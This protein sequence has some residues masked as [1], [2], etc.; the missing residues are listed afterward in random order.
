MNKSIIFMLL[1]VAGIAPKIRATGLLDSLRM[2]QIAGKNVV[3]HRADK[4]QS[5]YALL[6]KY[7]SS[8]ADFKE[9]NPGAD[10]NLQLGKVYKLA[11]GKPIKTAKVA[12]TPNKKA[13]KADYLKVEPGMTLYAVSR[14]TGLSVATIKKLNNL[15]DDNIE[16]GQMLLVNEQMSLGSIASHEVKHEDVKPETHVE[17]VVVTVKP[18][19]KPAVTQKVEKATEPKPEISAKT[20]VVEVKPKAEA[21]KKEEVKVITEPKKPVVEAPKE[22]VAAQKEEKNKELNQPLPTVEN[23]EAL[24]ISKTEEGV[25]EAIELESKSGKYLALHKSA[26]IGTL[27]QV[28]NETTGA[29]V[30]VKI[31]G[32]LPKLEQNENVVVKLSPKAMSRVSP[33][34]KRFR[35]KVFY[36][37]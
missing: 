25:A 2:E 19:E 21:P 16:V 22:V 18:E 23:T 37:L 31:V 26:P 20:E 12:A 8:M 35:A 3:L 4:G 13:A 15:K 10:I 33:V 17:R 32:K 28:R 27:M 24:G 30:W 29:T 11:Y 36:T 6:R 1:F 5:L 34:D 14:K 7:Q 9:L